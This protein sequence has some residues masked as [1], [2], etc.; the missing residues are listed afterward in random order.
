MADGAR[1]PPDRGRRPTVVELLE[2]LN[3]DGDGLVPSLDALLRLACASSPTCV[4][5]SLTVDDGTPVTVVAVVDQGRRRA[6]SMT[7][8]LP[9]PGPG[10][11]RRRPDV[12]VVFATDVLALARLAVV[13]GALLGIPEHR[14]VLVPDAPVPRPTAAGLLLA[15]Q[16]ADRGEVDRALGAL[17]EQG[18]LPD[19][20]GRGPSP[21]S[22]PEQGL[23]P[24]RPAPPGTTTGR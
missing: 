10:A 11:P 18:R 24:H 4:A 13:L 5:V 7:L 12:L 6:A 22:R 15:G 1:R 20:T 19:G 17:L 2:D 23:P 9:G 21:R 8:P 3:D 14:V 16:L